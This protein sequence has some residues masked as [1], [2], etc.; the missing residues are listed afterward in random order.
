MGLS[1]SRACTSWA[2]AIYGAKA[3]DVQHPRTRRCTERGTLIESTDETAEIRPCTA[4]MAAGCRPAMPG[5]S[6]AYEQWPISSDPAK[7]WI[8]ERKSEESVVAE[9]VGTA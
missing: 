4:K 1:G 6:E 2:K 7:E 5:N 3:F 9:M 8:A